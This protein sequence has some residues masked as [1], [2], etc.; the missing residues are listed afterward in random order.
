MPSMRVWFWCH[1]SVSPFVLWF[2]Q[3]RLTF[4]LTISQLRGV[5]NISSSIMVNICPWFATK[6]EN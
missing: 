2:F 4:P 3:I 1:N 6:Q 5:V